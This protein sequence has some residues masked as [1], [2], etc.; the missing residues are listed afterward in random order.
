MIGPSGKLLVVNNGAYGT[1]IAA[2]AERLKIPVTVVETVETSYPLEEFTTAL[3][4]DPEITHV[5][6]VHF[7]TTTGMLN[8]IE[9]WCQIAK[10]HGCQTRLVAGMRELGF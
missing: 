9:Q 6:F 3:S 4:A 1:R 2:I 7:E 8:P 5:A 10:E